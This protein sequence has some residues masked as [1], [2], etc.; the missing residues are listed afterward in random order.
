MIWILGLFERL[1][2]ELFPVLLEMKDDRFDVFARSQSVGVEI[3][4]RAMIERIGEMS[5]RDAVTAAG[6]GLD[7]ETNR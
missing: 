1:L 2:V 5:Q 3:R 6:S 4:T 7:G